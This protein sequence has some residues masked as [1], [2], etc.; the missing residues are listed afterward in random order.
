MYI[1]YVHCIYIKYIVNEINIKESH[2]NLNLSFGMF[3]E[4]NAL[5]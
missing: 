1:S 2:T 3:S 4:V 5:I